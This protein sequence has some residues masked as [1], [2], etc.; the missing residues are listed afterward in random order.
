MIAGGHRELRKNRGRHVECIAPPPEILVR[1]ISSSQQFVHTLARSG[2][3]LRI[4]RGTRDSRG[5]IG[6]ATAKRGYNPGRSR[7]DITTHRDDA[8][9]I[10]VR[11]RGFLELCSGSVHQRRSFSES[12]VG[13]HAL[14]CVD[15]DGVITELFHPVYKDQR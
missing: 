13:D 12:I 4:Q 10:Q 15:V 3:L 7:A 9:G 2:N 14:T 5:V 1:V 6:A 8:A 11:T